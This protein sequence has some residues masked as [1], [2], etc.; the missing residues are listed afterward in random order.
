MSGRVSKHGIVQHIPV[1]C[2]DD[3]PFQIRISYGDVDGL[4]ADIGQ[5]GLLQ[6]ILVRPRGDRYEVVHGHRRL[7]A[8]RSNGARFILGVVRELSDED[9]LLILGSENIHRK[10]LTPIE[11]AHLY[12]WYMEKMG[13]TP[14]RVAEAFKVSAE[15]VRSKLNLLD[16]PE[17]IQARIHDGELSYTKARQLAILT[18]EPSTT[19]VVHGKKEDGTFSSVEPQPAQRTDRWHQEIRLLAEDPGLRTEREVAEA[20]RLVREGTPVGEAVEKAREKAGA[21][22]S[23]RRAGEKAEPP[24]AIMRRILERQPDPSTLDEDRRRL[25][26]EVVAGLL[27]KGVLVCP[28][29]GGD[30]LAWACTGR[31]AADE[32]A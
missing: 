19:T 14:A 7:R 12:Q 28:D 24:E 29:C 16:L 20:A 31:R 8:V 25:T 9:A 27:R 5:R 4:A 30:D 1:D 3:S 6:P 15:N 22:G 18:R 10:D 23:R 2:I 13:K 17:D 11:E 26:R 21:E 32:G